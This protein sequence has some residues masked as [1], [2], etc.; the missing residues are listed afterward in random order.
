MGNQTDSLPP[1]LLVLNKKDLIKPGEIA[2]KLEVSICLLISMLACN[3]GSCCSISF[4]KTQYHNHILQWYE[5]FTNVD[6]VIPVSAKHGQGVEDV[7]QW[8]LSKLPFGPA[9]YP[10]V[11]RVSECHFWAHGSSLTFEKWT[12]GV[13]V[14]FYSG[15]YPTRKE[16]SVEVAERYEYCTTNCTSRH[17]LLRITKNQYKQVASIASFRALAL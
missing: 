12:P 17:C 14:V 16:S 15:F 4:F 8:I 1:T 13:P 6:E 5:K 7:K 9:Y 3:S 11:L 10:K 2:K